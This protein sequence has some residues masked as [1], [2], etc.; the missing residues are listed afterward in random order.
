[1]KKKQI[2]IL[3]VVLAILAVVYG[4]L[5]FGNKKAKEEEKA[6]EENQV[7]Q[8]ADLGE[9]LSF[10]YE[11]P[12]QEPLRFEKEK[13]DWVCAD[14]KKMELEQTYPSDIADAFASLTASRKME[15]I[16]ALEDYGLKEPAYT[17]TLQPKDG[18]EMTFYI[19]DSTGDEYYLQAEGE[20]DVIYTVASS[21]V[22]TLDHSLEDMKKTEEDEDAEADS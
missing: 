13:D 8:V 7:I 11:A 17:V 5:S 2:L 12:E 3:A 10:S 21:V 20:E 19:G 9:I 1:M 14:D 16:D 22:M 6:Q 15:E 4:A 18:K